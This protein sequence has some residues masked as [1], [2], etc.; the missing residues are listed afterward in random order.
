MTIRPIAGL[1]LAAAF[2]FSLPAAFAQ[3][4][5]GAKQSMKNAGSETKGAAKDTGHGIKQGTK[6]A[7]H[8]TKSGTKKAARK[9]SGKPSEPSPQ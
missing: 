9:V 7:Y 2:T 5:S 6:K 8:K 3:N 4:D 1:V